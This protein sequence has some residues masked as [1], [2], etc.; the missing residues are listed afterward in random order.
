LETLS[1]IDIT[2]RLPA[3][4]KPDIFIPQKIDSRC[5]FPLLFG[6]VLKCHFVRS[7]VNFG[8]GG[9]FGYAGSREQLAVNGQMESGTVRFWTEFAGVAQGRP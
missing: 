7:S 6:G 5:H 9:R 4:S 1:S 8:G 2:Y 3:S